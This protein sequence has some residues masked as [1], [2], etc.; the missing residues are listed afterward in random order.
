MEEQMTR[1]QAIEM[2]ESGWWKNREPYEIVLFQLFESRLCMD[3]GDFQ[4]ATEQVLGRSVWTHEFADG[5]SLRKEFL[6]D[7]KPPTFQEIMEMIPEAKRII[8][9]MDNAPQSKD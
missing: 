5:D 9:R 4:E 8:V 1:E 2:A 7:K 6:G 3:F